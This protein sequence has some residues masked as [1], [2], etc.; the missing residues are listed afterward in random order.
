[1]HEIHQ[2]LLCAR[3]M[4]FYDIKEMKH[5]YMLNNHSKEK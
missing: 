2:K 4:T 5:N 1:M 3:V